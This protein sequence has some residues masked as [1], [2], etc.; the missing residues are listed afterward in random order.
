MSIFLDTVTS[1]YLQLP[2]TKPL[3]PEIRHFII[4]IHK[5]N[6]FGKIQAIKF[7]ENVFRNLQSQDFVINVI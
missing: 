5:W 4:Q 2:K 1:L 7:Q 3:S 6:E